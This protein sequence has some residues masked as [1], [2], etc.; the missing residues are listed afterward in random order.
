MKLNIKPMAAN[1]KANGIDDSHN[2]TFGDSDCIARMA[3][4][5]EGASTPAEILVL[6]PCQSVETS[7][8]MR[9]VCH[10]A[11]TIAANA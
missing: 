9:P 8:A 11:R 10:N 6:K 5:M 4:R 3:K 7:S 2:P 1:T